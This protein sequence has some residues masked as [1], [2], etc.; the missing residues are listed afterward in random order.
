M[1]DEE[2]GVGVGDDKGGEGI[3]GVDGGGS[4][5]L[6]SADAGELFGGD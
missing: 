5:E 6:T 1:T 2:S 4:F 3:D